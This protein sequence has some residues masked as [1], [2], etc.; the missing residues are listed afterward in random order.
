MAIQLDASQLETV[1][2]ILHV[3][4]EGLKVLAY[5][6]RVSGVNLTPESDLDIA[7]VSEKPLNF[8][9]MVAVEKAFADSELPFRVDIVDWAK[10]P[11][12]LQKSI[13]KENFVIQE[14]E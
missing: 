1:R 3:H 5:G 7:V 6:S 8:D 13:K 4:F 12:S 9:E 11:E 2:R 10:M 14:E